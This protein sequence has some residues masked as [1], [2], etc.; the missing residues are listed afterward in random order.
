MK[1]SRASKIDVKMVA[2][3]DNWVKI[4][5]ADDGIG[6]K[7]DT[8]KD[9]IGLKNIRDRLKLI[10]GHIDIIS[11]PTKGTSIDLTL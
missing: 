3:N 9:G 6:F 5:V 11:E 7:T 10:G 2:S 4:S 8:F 1:H